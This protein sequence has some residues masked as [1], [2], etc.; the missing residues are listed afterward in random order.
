MRDLM[1]VSGMSNRVELAN[2]GRRTNA[3]LCANELKSHSAGFGQEPANTGP[4]D[5]RAFLFSARQ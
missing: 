4:A 2:W 1:D 5:S 3:R